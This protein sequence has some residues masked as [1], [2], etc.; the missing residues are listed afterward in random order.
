M[1][2]WVNEWRTAQ[3]G[4]AAALHTGV[5]DPYLHWVTFPTW[6]GGSEVVHNFVFSGQGG[7]SHSCGG[8]EKN[9]TFETYILEEPNVKQM[10]SI[11]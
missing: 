4:V 11:N 8:E 5:H 3:Q 2:K 6:T 1:E 10:V 9:Q 7:N